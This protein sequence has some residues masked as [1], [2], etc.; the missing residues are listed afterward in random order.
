T[1]TLIVRGIRAVYT[2]ILRAAL[3][4]RKVAVLAGL[5]FVVL[6]GFLASNLGTEFLPALEEGNL[7]IRAS[8]PPTVS[9][10]S[11]MPAVTKMR[12]ILLSHPE[13]IT[14]VSQHGRPDDG[15][16]AAGFYNAEFFVPLKPLEQWSPGLT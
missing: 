16:D 3:A 1:E 7:W 12:E 11:A 5:T 9:L 15:S 14:V 8:M 6:C 13:V 4:F 2:P 10:E